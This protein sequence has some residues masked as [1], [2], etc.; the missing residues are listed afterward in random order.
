MNSVIWNGKWPHSFAS[1]NNNVFQITDYNLSKT[2]ISSSALI[3]Y[4]KNTVKYSLNPYH[5]LNSK[6]KPIVRYLINSTDENSSCYQNYALKYHQNSKSSFSQV[7]I[8]NNQN[9]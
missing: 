2:P 3:N 7:L 4:R 8:D 6:K 1:F 9:K 5:I